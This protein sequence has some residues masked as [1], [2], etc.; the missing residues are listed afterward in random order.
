MKKNDIV[1]INKLDKNANIAESTKVAREAFNFLSTKRQL[2]MIYII[3]SMVEPEDTKFTQYQIPFREVAKIMNPSNPDCQI[4]KNDVIKA[5]ENIVNSGFHVTSKDGRRIRFYHWIETAEI[6]LDEKVI[7]FKINDEVRDFYLELQRGQ[8]TVYKLKEM[9]SLTSIFQCNV[10]R[11]CSANSNFKNTV[12][13]NIED[14]K[15]MFDQTDIRTNAFIEKM[16]TA[17]KRINEKTSLHVEYQIVRKGR[18]IDH[19]VFTI[20]NN[21]KLTD[22]KQD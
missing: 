11:W 21:Y 17:V 20:K 5:T 13:L 18:N 22:K 15:K 3:I 14:A 12:C 6:D 1:K 9:L 19:L 7:Y 2:E 10:F 8:Y 4:T 16:N